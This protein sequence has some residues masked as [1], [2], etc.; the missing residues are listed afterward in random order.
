[1]H[2]RHLPGVKQQLAA[3]NVF[4]LLREDAEHCATVATVAQA[5]AL[6]D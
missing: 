6:P 4:A 1:V 3:S 2:E 5:A